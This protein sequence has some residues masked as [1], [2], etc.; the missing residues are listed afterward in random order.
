MLFIQHL[1]GS[2]ELTHSPSHFPQ[3]KEQAKEDPLGFCTAPVQ[4]LSGLPL[5][6]GTTAGGRA[7]P[8]IGAA[9]AEAP[10]LHLL[11]WVPWEAPAGKEC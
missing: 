10:S 11:S 9:L 2:Q 5:E 6:L 1:W 8:G 7:P 3:D 4:P